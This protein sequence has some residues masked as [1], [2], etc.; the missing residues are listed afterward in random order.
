MRKKHV[1]NA[2]QENIKQDE[3]TELSQYV[4]DKESSASTN[5]TSSSEPECSKYEKSKSGNII[6]LRDVE[7]LTFENKNYIKLKN[8]LKNQLKILE[9]EKAVL[10]KNDFEKQNIINSHREKITQLEQDAEIAK[11]KIEDLEMKLK[12]FVA[13]SLMLDNIV[14]KPIK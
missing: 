7:S 5:E 9:N 8:D 11:I 3:S 12:G 13:S 6:L 14:P 2:H 4:E 1:D 10:N